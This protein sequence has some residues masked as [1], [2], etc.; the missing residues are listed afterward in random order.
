[1][2]RGRVIAAPLVTIRRLK[3]VGAALGV[4]GPQERVAV[5]AGLHVDLA[6]G[7]RRRVERADAVEGVHP[8][9]LTGPGVEGVQRA[10]VDGHEHASVRG[11]DRIDGR[12][13]GNGPPHVEDIGVQHQRDVAGVARVALI[14][15]PPGLHLGGGAFAVGVVVLQDVE[16]AVVG[17]EGGV[18]P[19]ESLGLDREVLRVQDQVVERCHGVLDDAGAARLPQIA[20][21][22]ELVGELVEPERAVGLTLGVA[23]GRPRDGDGEQ[24]EYVPGVDPLQLVHVR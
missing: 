2:G 1:M 20:V 7:I 10:V 15:L 24:G 23:R 3:Q 17:R 14:R 13:H 19:L 6:T 11:R 8:L 22:R 5:P 18:D 21:R 12:A 9:E 16:H 4:E